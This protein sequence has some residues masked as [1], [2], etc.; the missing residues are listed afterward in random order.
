LRCDTRIDGALV[1]S[2]T[3]ASVNGGPLAA[4]AF[5]LRCNALRGRPLRAGDLIST[6]AAT[7]VHSIGA[8]QLAEVAF[9]GIATLACR[10]V[11]MI[12]VAGDAC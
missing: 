9:D 12:P 7:G 6:G 3:A 4:L 10:T 1:G 11:P 8:G 2:G 5:A